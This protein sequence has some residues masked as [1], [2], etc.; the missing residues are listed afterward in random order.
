MVLLPAASD[1]HQDHQ[2]IHQEGMR[3]FRIRPSPAM[4]YHG[5]IT[6]FAQISL[7]EFLRLTLQK[8]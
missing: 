2:V 6:A 4:N 5:I 3:A 7:F 1:I 8:K